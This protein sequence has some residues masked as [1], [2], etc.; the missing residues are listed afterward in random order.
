MDFTYNDID[1][2]YSSN[3]NKVTARLYGERQPTIS[4]DSFVAA[5]AAVKDRL[6]RIRAKEIEQS[7]NRRAI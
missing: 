6:E 4:A 5:K 2:I 1:A 7:W 3:S